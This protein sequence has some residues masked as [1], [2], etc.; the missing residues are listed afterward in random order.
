VGTGSGLVRAE[1]AVALP[2]DADFRSPAGDLNQLSITIG[3]T[4]HMQGADARINGGVWIPLS[5][6]SGGTWSTTTSVPQDAFVQFRARGTFGSETSGCYRWPAA[7]PTECAPATT[8]T[9][10][11]APAPAPAPSATFT[12]KGGNAWWAEVVVKAEGGKAVTQVQARDVNTPWTGLK[13][14]SWGVWTGSLH[15]E[16]GNTIQYR[17]MV[18][19]AWVESC[20][21]THPG[22]VAQCSTSAPAPAPA[23]TFQATWKNMRGNAWWVE[24]D[25]AT[26]G[27]TLAGV[28]ARVDGG[29]WTALSKQSYGSWAK[30]IHAPAGSMVEFRARATDGQ[31]AVSPA[32][33][34]PR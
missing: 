24:T 13:L 4:Q 25:V 29:G 20:A 10:A 6:G 3:A 19:G 14:Q 21:Y 8:A 1:L 22:G 16:K 18:G 34:W 28:D 26:S 31:A 33:A 17:A 11:P 7:T 2:F 5:G 27:G 9:P 15:V 23:P 12:P 32:V 30:S